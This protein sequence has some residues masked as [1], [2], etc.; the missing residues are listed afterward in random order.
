MRLLANNLYNPQFGVDRPVVDQTGLEGRFDYML[1]L[2]AG[3]ISLGA[4]P[5]NPDALSSFLSALREQLGLK[6]E[7]SRG[8][9]RM[10][11]IDHVEPA[12]QN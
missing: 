3:I 10:L 1:E 11:I 9:V 6:L 2:P 12:S 4:K 7:R 8:A 5:P